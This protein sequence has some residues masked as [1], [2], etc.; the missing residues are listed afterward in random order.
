MSSYIIIKS[1]FLFKILTVDAEMC[2]RIRYSFV[3]FKMSSTAALSPSLTVA[4]RALVIRWRPFDPIVSRRSLGLRGNNQSN[5]YICFYS[6]S[7]VASLN[8]SLSFAMIAQA[9]LSF[10]RESSSISCFFCFL[11]LFCMSD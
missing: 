3:N 6:V 7:R 11:I 8:R 1:F 10:S 4:A 9:N 2:K 5:S